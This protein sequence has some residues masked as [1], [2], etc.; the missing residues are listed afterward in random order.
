MVILL[1]QVAFY[2]NYDSPSLASILVPA[3]YLA[4]VIFYLVNTKKKITE[5][6]QIEYFLFFSYVFNIIA[7]LSIFLNEPYQLTTTSYICIT[8]TNIIIIYLFRLEGSIGSP[9]TWTDYLKLG[10]FLYMFTLLANEET[11][12]EVDDNDYFLGL[13]YALEEFVIIIL[14]LYRPISNLLSYRLMILHF[15]LIYFCDCLFFFYQYSGNAP[16]LSIISYLLF[17]NGKFLQA[18]AFMLREED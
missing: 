10:V 1:I 18:L 17:F 6:T 12:S 11:I 13:V 9:Q 4:I 16:Q 2:Y 15:V 5:L 8:I 14:T 3:H 7:D